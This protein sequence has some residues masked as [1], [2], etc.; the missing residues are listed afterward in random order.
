[1]I[2]K[3]SLAG[4]VLRMYR[5]D[6]R[7]HVRSAYFVLG[8]FQA[9][10]AVLRKSLLRSYLQEKEGTVCEEEEEEEEI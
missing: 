4:A 5:T 9:F 6:P 3:P 2:P 1:M 8:P 7:W 10:P